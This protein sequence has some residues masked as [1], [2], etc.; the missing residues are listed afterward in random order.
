MKLSDKELLL[1]EESFDLMV[2]HYNSEIEEIRNL[3]ETFYEEKLK[4]YQRRR[5]QYTIEDLRDK[6]I[7]EEL[8]KITK[9]K[10][11]KKKLLLSD[12]Y[13]LVVSKLI[14]LTLSEK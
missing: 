1:L 4:R 11:L 13:V 6:E 2:E 9:V 8:N 3:D 14:R 10:E 5:K 7:Q 12:N